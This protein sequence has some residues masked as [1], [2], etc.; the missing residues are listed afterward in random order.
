MNQFQK[1]IKNTGSQI[2]TKISAH[3]FFFQKL[4]DDNINA[5]SAHVAFFI[6]ISFFPFA[7]FLLTLLSYLPIPADT[8]PTLAS[9]MFPAVFNDFLRE[10]LEELSV[11]ASGTILSITVIAA[12]WSAS[13]GLLSIMRGLNR[14]Y[15]IP[16]TRNYFVI[17]FFSTL[18][19]LA[20]AIIILVFLVIFVFGNQLTLYFLDKFPIIGS[21]ALLVK[22]IRSVAGIGILLFFFLLLYVTIPNRRSNILRELPGALVA[23]FGW[24]G[25]SFLYS[26]YIDNMG[27]YSATYGSLTAIVLCMLWLYICM[28]LMF[29]GA[30]I[31]VAFSEKIVKTLRKK[32]LAKKIARKGKPPITDK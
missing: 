7:M 23:A 4:N 29:L 32:H 9:E 13:R 14:I 25:F 31:N 3:N 24:V 6:I 19:T 27:N 11:A 5:L 16:E 26:F 2:Q 18:Y 22:S 12:L 17:R 20:F 30:E 1:K 28:Y 15:N 21:Y 10:I 8:L